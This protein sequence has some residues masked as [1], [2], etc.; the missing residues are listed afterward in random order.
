MRRALLFL[1]GCIPCVEW[2][3]DVKRD[4]ASARCGVSR[5]TVACL[6]LRVLSLSFQ[7]VAVSRVGRRD[8]VSCL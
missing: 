7:G 5:S 8:L 3:Y 2:V 4:L 1:F 6:S